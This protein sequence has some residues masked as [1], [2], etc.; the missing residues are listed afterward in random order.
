[1]TLKYGQFI[2]VEGIDGSGK[3]TLI[4]NMKEKFEANGV[5]VNVFSGIGEG[6]VGRKLKT[7]CLDLLS[8]FGSIRA[9]EVAKQ[10]TIIDL[11]LSGV[12]NCLLGYVYPA[13]MRGEVVILDRFFH[14]T[15][16]YQALTHRFEKYF[17]FCLNAKKDAYPNNSVEPDYIVFCNTTAELSALRSKGR[18]D[19]N[20]IDSWTVEA[21]QDIINRYKTTHEWYTTPP[22]EN[23][24]IIHLNTE[25]FSKLDLSEIEEMIET[26]TTL[27]KEMEKQNG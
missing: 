18:S 23:T 3:T 4:S 17:Y 1:M 5:K 22:H 11:F 10:N 20:I 7:M 24:K 27:T 9:L 21:K 14:S 8:S 6:D 12:F 16:A 15:F 13:I 19:D 26:V 25:D 2:V